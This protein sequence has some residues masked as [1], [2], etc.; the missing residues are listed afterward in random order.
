MTGA[1]RRAQGLAIRG[2]DERERLRVMLDLAADRHEDR[3]VVAD[4]A[5]DVVAGDVGRRDDDDLRPVEGGIEIERDEAGMGVGRPDRRAEPGAREDE[6][7]GVLRL[8]GELRGAL[9]AER[10]GAAGRDRPS[11]CP[12]RR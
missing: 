8:A 10:S 5:H 3:L 4:Q 1:A 7:V 6:V 11:T 12:E 9:P 2:R